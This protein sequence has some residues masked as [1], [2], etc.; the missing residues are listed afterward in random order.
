MD[1]QVQ[2][3]AFG[4]Q[5]DSFKADLVVPEIKQSTGARCIPCDFISTPS[6]RKSGP[7]AKVLA[8]LPDKRIVAAQ[9][10]IPCHS[11]HPELTNGTRF[12]EYFLRLWIDRYIFSDGEIWLHDGQIAS[13][14]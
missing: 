4:R 11:F 1:I 8:A 3:N 7:D 9:Q 6:S 5:V 13:L 10:G 14:G 2:R 12:H